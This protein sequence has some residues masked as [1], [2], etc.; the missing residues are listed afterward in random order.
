[1]YRTSTPGG[2]MLWRT[3]G[4][5]A[6]QGHNWNIG[7]S[8]GSV[9]AARWHPSAVVDGYGTPLRNLSAVA[10]ACILSLVRKHSRW[11]QKAQYDSDIGPSTSAARLFL[12]QKHFWSVAAPSC[13]LKSVILNKSAI[14]IG[15]GPKHCG[16]STSASR[17]RRQT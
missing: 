4:A 12:S 9:L 6:R 8:G 1:M 11:R 14:V 7:G 15:L 2:M 17:E 3:Q 5:A 13:S 10:R 16:L